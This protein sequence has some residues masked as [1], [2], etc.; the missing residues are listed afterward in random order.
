MLGA[1]QRVPSRDRM[2]DDPIVGQLLGNRTRVVSYCSD[3]AGSRTN[4]RSFYVN[5]GQLCDDDRLVILSD[6]ISYNFIKN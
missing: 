2:I 5:G 4:M 3:R 1:L 6:R